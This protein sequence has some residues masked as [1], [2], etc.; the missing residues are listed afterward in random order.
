MVAKAGATKLKEDCCCPCFRFRAAVRLSTASTHTV[1]VA[2]GS[3]NA[4]TPLNATSM[5]RKTSHTPPLLM[6]P[7]ARN[8]ASTSPSKAA[9]ARSLPSRK[10]KTA[11]K[12]M[13]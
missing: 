1:P 4:F 3:K 10:D 11:S 8:E 7:A 13:S 5:S 6:S 2:V 12:S 9:L